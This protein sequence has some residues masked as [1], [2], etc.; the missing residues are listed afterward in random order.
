[1]SQTPPSRPNLSSMADLDTPRPRS[2][3]R[4]HFSDG[5]STPRFRGRTPYLGQS[6]TPSS[7]AFDSEDMPPNLLEDLQPPRYASEATLFETPSDSAYLRSTGYAPSSSPNNG[8]TIGS[9]PSAFPASVF[10]QS[11]NPPSFGEEP[12]YN[13]DID[14]GEDANLELDPISGATTNL[15]EIAALDDGRNSLNKKAYSQT[16]DASHLSPVSRGASANSSEETKVVE[17]PDDIEREMLRKMDYKQ[18]RKERQKIKIE[19]NITSRSHKYANDDD[20]DQ[21]RRGQ[22]PKISFKTRS[23]SYGFRFSFPQDRGSING[24]F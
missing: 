15:V 24:L 6:Y 16:L 8:H 21:F 7:L 1:M 12:F 13:E 4:V 2:S 14:G 9:Q 20:P 23:C 3:S 11:E 5:L 10:R 19:Y 17:N 18:R 22:S